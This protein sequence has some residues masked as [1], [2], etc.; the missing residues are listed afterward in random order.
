L[1]VKNL[2]HF[3]VKK[4]Y[5]WIFKRIFLSKKLLR[6]GMINSWVQQSISKHKKAMYIE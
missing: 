5:K 3:F 1:I 4:S 2:K 6:F